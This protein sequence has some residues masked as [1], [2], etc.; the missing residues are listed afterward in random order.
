MQLD[1]I[2]L[3]NKYVRLV[4]ICYEHKSALCDVIS[5]GELWKL[6]VT[7]VPPL[8]AIDGFIEQAISAQTIG[9]G[10]TFVTIDKISDKVVGST[11]FMKANFPY[12]RIEIG[13]TFIAETFQR[14]RVNTEAKYLMLEYA[15]ETLNMNRVEFLTDYLNLKSRN[16]LLRLGAKEEGVL[17]NHMVMPNGR[18]RDSVI[19]SIIKNEWPG[20]KQHLNSKR[21][22][23]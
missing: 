6:F 10:L 5:D 16:A 4:P 22:N 15:F 7:L 21:S 12:Q 8:E 23:E 11:R 17:R 20:I 1:K 13:Y 18:I 14:T 2:V 9:D 3:E 19:F